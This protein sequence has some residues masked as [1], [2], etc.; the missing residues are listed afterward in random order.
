MGPLALG[1]ALIAV[2]A[3]SSAHTVQ[4]AS[5]QKN[6]LKLESITPSRSTPKGGKTPVVTF[7]QKRVPW[8]MSKKTGKM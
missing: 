1:I 2:V 8:K 4:A 5:A 6:K 7:T 3:L